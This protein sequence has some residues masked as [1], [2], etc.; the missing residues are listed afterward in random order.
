MESMHQE[1]KSNQ[2]VIGTCVTL[3]VRLTI[4]MT[5]AKNGSFTELVLGESAAFV[6][7]LSQETS[8]QL[9]SSVVTGDDPNKTVLRAAKT[10]GGECV[11]VFMNTIDN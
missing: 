1:L 4:T 9:A 8:K 2:Q 7:I 11:Y 3:H 10:F 5:T 6:L